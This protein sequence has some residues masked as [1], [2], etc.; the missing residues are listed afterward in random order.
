MNDSILIPLPSGEVSVSEIPDQ[1]IDY[2]LLEELRLTGPQREALVPKLTDAAL[3]QHLNERILPNTVPFLRRH[4]TPITYDES[5]AIL[6]VPELIRR[7]E[8]R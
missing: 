3:A 7:I 8:N 2:E 1:S 4:A 6:Y 5:L